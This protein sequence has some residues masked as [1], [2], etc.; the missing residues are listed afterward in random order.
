MI[1]RERKGTKISQ[2][3]ELLGKGMSHKDIAA[4][5]NISPGTAKTYSVQ[6]YRRYGVEG[7]LDFYIMFNGQIREEETLP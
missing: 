4:R 1:F 7:R 6:L 3:A 2:V 5:L